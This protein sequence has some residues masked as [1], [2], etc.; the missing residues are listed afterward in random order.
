MAEPVSIPAGTTEAA[1][2][3]AAERVNARSWRDETLISPAATWLRAHLH[4]EPIPADDRNLRVWI[5]KIVAELQAMSTDP[6]FAS[7]FT[8][9]APASDAKGAAGPVDKPATGQSGSTPPTS[10]PKAGATS[11]SQQKPQQQPQQQPGGQPQ[12]S[13]T[14]PQVVA[15]PLQTKLPVGA[16]KGLKDF[17]ACD[18]DSVD[19]GSG[20]VKW[21]G[22]PVTPDIGFKTGKRPN[23]A[24]MT[25]DVGVAFDLPVSI[26]NGQ[27]HVDTS[28]IPDL[29]LI[30]DKLKNAT[31]EVQRYVHGLN[32]DIKKGGKCFTG[33]TV[34]EGVITLTKDKL[35]TPGPQPPGLGGSGTKQ[36]EKKK[37]RVST[38][39]KIAIGAG[40]IGVVAVVGTVVAVDQ[41]GNNSST[42]AA[43]AAPTPVQPTGPA[44]SSGMT[45][46]MQ[47]FVARNSN[48]QVSV[49]TDLT[50]AASSDPSVEQ[51]LSSLG[52]TSSA[53]GELQTA[54]L[55]LAQLASSPDGGFNAG[56]ANVYE[57]NSAA[58]ARKFYDFLSAR[59]ANAPGSAPLSAAIQ[60]V[61]SSFAYSVAGR[62]L[63]G[64]PVQ[65]VTVGAI[66]DNR[67]VTFSFFGTFPSDTARNAQAPSV[68][69]D[70]NQLVAKVL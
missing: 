55:S 26:Q 43:S 32:A 42:H 40:C 49:F 44:I 6:A 33:I 14:A 53:T 23:T 46:F 2:S 45:D 64:P 70:F 66:K 31:A 47:S 34:K 21:A 8:K 27:L 13:V 65:S 57:F 52:L 17:V 59:W 61:S 3:E 51:E 35:A 12:T 16:P 41:G 19:L 24:V 38:G 4:S 1:I 15:V 58:D 60:G 69:D 63:T 11:G 25:V 39:R 22:L 10:T 37:G 50:H 67:V 62:Q 68:V 36:P 9:V 56:L 54:G 28:K 30:T 48:N 18:A 7:L 5:D 29:S 20:P